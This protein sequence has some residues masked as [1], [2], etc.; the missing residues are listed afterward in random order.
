MKNILNDLHRCKF[1]ELVSCST[2]LDKSI[3]D[4]SYC[5]KYQRYSQRTENNPLQ[6]L[7]FDFVKRHV[8]HGR[9]LDFGC[10][11]GSFLQFVDGQFDE[12]NGFDINP[13]S[14]F[15]NIDV[16][17]KRYYIVTFWDSLE[18]LERPQ[19]VIEGLNPEYVFISTPSTDDIDFSNILNWRHY[20][21]EE[22]AHFFNRNSLTML[23]DSI[24]YKVIDYNYEESVI[25]TSGGE[26]NILSIAAKKNEGANK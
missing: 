14:G 17:L 19:D 24:G 18:H 8:N 10:G 5:L 20:I 21:P 7:R 13:Y 22:H 12:S 23:L 1:C 2:P 9:L 26:K 25:R 11:N 3:Y 16:L 4:K 15:L 6:Q